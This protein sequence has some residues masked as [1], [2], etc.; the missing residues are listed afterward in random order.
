[1]GFRNKKKKQE[2]R[3]FIKGIVAKFNAS[4]TGEIKITRI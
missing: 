2:R 1:M 3:K 4:Y